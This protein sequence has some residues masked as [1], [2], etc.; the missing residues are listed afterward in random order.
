MGRYRTIRSA[1]RIGGSPTPR[2]RTSARSLLPPNAVCTVSAGI[3]QRLRSAAIDRS[4]D[5]PGPLLGSL[6]QTSP[7]QFRGH[8]T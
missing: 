5:G 8:H 6:H 2:S 1:E 4:Q 7:S 3:E